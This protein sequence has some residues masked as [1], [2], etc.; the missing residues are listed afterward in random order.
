[1]TLLTH[2]CVIRSVELLIQLLIKMNFSL[3][4]D[5]M[6]NGATGYVDGSNLYGLSDE[7][8]AILLTPSGKVNILVCPE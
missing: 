4:E 8:E 3:I 1:M 2:K 7:E 5:G 6:V